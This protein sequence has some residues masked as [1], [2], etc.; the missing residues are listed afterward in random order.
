MDPDEDRFTIRGDWAAERSPSIVGHYSL[1]DFGK[2]AVHDLSAGRP[3]IINDDLAELAPEEAA[4]FQAI[5]I[6]ATICMPLIKDG[7]LTALMAIHDWV[8]RTWSPYQLALITEVTERSWAHIERVRAVAALRD[9]VEK[10]ALLNATLEERVEER[11]A[12]LVDAEAALRQSQKLEAVGQLTGGVAHDFNNLLTIIR[13]STSTSCAG[14]S[15][16]RIAAP[17]YL[18][19]VS[20]T[21]EPSRQ[22]SQVSSWPLLAGRR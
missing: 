20:D 15:C 2:R 16:R 12:Q 18:N 3:L 9:A 13:S 14:P 6:A 4:T 8:P 10:L 21:V 5:G 7:R 1:A 19:A 11:T 17:R 22:N